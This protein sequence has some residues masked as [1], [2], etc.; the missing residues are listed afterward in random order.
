[1]NN[2]LTNRKPELRADMSELSA[3]LD[4]LTPKLAE[5]SGEVR[6]LLFCLRDIPPD[7]LVTAEFVFASRT[8]GTLLLKPSQLL[9]DLGFAIRTNKLD[10]LLFERSHGFSFVDNRL[11]EL[12]IL[13]TLEK[14]T[15]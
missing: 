7:L 6:E 13:S 14:P 2:I 8:D 12:P 1:M 11:V 9:L 15:N 5:V 4:E 3:L 10:R